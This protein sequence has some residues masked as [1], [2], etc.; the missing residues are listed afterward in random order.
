MTNKM[1]KIKGI[2]LEPEGFDSMMDVTAVVNSSDRDSPS[3][4]TDYVWWVNGKKLF[5]RTTETLSHE[6]YAKGDEVV[7]EITVSDEESEVTKKSRPVRVANAAPV[8]TMDPRF[9]DKIDGTRV[10]AEDPDGDKI[11]YKLK[12]EPLGMSIDPKQGVISYE[13]SKEAR[14]GTYSVAVLAEDGGGKNLQWQFQIE[15]KG[16][17]GPDKKEEPAG[18]DKDAKSEKEDE[19][20]AAQ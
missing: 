3:L 7:V 12:G 2:K 17:S 20:K 19:E 14:S 4:D 13:G 8:W 15:V 10:I 11:T 18:V 16:G 1:P 9:F 6:E 5:H